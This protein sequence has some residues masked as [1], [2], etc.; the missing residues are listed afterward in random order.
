MQEEFLQFIWNAMPLEASELI[1]V[2]GFEV[3]VRQRGEWNILSG[4]DFSNAKLSIN[5]L[6]WGGD[7]EIHLKSSDW[8]AHKHH[9][10]PAYD[11]VILHVVFNDDKPA[12]SSKGVRIPTLV[13]REDKWLPSYWR[14]E[15]WLNNN[16][17]FTCESLIGSVPGKLKNDWVEE[18]GIRRWN[19]KR[20]QLSKLRKELKGNELKMRTVLMAR[21]MGEPINSLPLMTLAKR[22]PDYRVIRHSWLWNDFAG[23][24][25]ALTG[26]SENH[27]S[28]YYLKKFEVEPLQEGMWKY[29]RLRPPS[30]PKARVAQ[31][32]WW[33]YRCVIKGLVQNPFDEEFWKDSEL[34]YLPGKSTLLQ[35]KINSDW[36]FD[37][38]NPIS[39][40]S[41]GQWQNLAAEYNSITKLFREKGVNNENALQSQGAL[42]LYTSFCQNKKCLHCVIG[43]YL[44]KTNNYD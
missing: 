34:E 40:N 36:W 9:N 29:G 37:V 23:W 24:V 14:Y 16:R 30:F 35:W 8:F 26:L 39:E 21:L 3:Q 22:L 12:V 28:S 25:I 1:T 20:L 31:W 2:D 38:R 19:R 43:K 10:D 11:K 15:R 32:T 18:L 17:S 5:G 6:D 4:P 27:Q 7:V 41:K 44:M 33:Y 42:E 13:L